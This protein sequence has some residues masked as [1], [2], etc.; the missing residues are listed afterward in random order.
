MPPDAT[1]DV[2]Q[3][4]RSNHFH[5]VLHMVDEGPGRSRIEWLMVDLKGEPGSVT[6]EDTPNVTMNQDRAILES[7][8][9]N[10]DRAGADFERSVPADFP[11]L[12]LRKAV[13][14]AGSGEWEAR[15]GEL[16]QRK[17]VRVR[18]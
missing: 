15:R 9:K 17:L 14:L 1:V 8:Q 6:W 16:T 18:Q 2:F 7:A 5:L 10:Y 12:L 11:L 3:R 13:A 4:G